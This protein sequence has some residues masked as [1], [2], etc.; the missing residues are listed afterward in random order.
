MSDGYTAH[1][2]TSGP[3]GPGNL[4]QPPRCL[5]LRMECG[6]AFQLGNKAPRSFGM[7]QLQSATRGRD[8]GQGTSTGDGRV[9][10]R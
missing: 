2:M 10:S 7:R 1:S 3:H 8:D 6:R 4:G 9:A 5:H